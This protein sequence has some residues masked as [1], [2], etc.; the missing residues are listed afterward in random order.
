MG[1][2]ADFEC[3]KCKNLFE[4]HEGGTFEIEA[5][6]CEK[7]DELKGVKRGKKPSKCKC[8][9]IFKTN[10]TPMCPKCKTRDVKMKKVKLF[11]D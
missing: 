7:C 1:H 6:R 5:Y 8:G 3:N 11:Y 9:G 10:L 4:S 2:L